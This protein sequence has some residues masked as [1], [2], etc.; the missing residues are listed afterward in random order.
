M[1]KKRAGQTKINRRIVNQAFA[2][3]AVQISQEK[4]HRSG[5]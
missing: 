1:S 4:P 3:G 2:A 5:S